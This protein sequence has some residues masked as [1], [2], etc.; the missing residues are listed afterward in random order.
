LGY[1]ALRWRIEDFHLTLKS[2]CQVE[3]LQ[4]ET[5]NRLSKAIVTYSAVALRIMALRDLARQEPTVPCDRILNTDQWHALYAHFQGHRPSRDT[6]VPTI[7]E[8]VKWIGRL[9]GHLGRKRDGMPGVRT[10]WRGWRDLSLL[11]A[12]YRAARIDALPASD[13]LGGVPAEVDSDP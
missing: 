9:G 10:L 7:R 1:Y 6:P 4:L 13:A 11:V 3:Q 2:G 12:G 8:A 5:A